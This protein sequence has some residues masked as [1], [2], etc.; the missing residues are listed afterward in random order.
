MAWDTDW[1]E[2]SR[3]KANR[4]AQ[5]K[6][7]ERNQKKRDRER[8]RGARDAERAGEARRDALERRYFERCAEEITGT[9][10]VANPKLWDIHSLVNG[11][12][13][14]HKRGLESR[15]FLEE[16]RGHL[17]ETGAKWPNPRA[18]LLA[19]REF[20]REK[21]FYP[22]LVESLRGQAA[23]LFSDFEEG[24]DSARAKGE[25]FWPAYSVYRRAVYSML[26]SL[27]VKQGV[28]GPDYRWDDQWRAIHR[29]LRGFGKDED[30]NVAHSISGS[31]RSR[32]R[33]KDKAP[34]VYP[35]LM[36]RVVECA[37]KYDPTV[38]LRSAPLIGENSAP[39]RAAKA[40][41]GSAAAE[42]GGAASQAAKEKKRGQQRLF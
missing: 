16:W 4:E 10:G 41:V 32:P 30:R 3:Q 7:A 39:A 21:F 15:W 9:S 37:A 27:D 12:E 40:G 28:E 38:Y 42:Q 13:Y 36:R 33:A 6:Q 31:E 17:K 11:L 25:S 23:C 14:I 8:A 35:L 19:K 20:F 22:F 24:R 34:T 1:N 18:E 26:E 29:E 2:V 5:R